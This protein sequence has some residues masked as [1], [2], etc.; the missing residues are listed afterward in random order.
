MASPEVNVRIRA[1]DEA[2]PVLQLIKG[3]LSEIEPAGAR[4]GRGVDKLTDAVKDI[5]RQAAGVDRDVGNL[6]VGLINLAGGGTLV[7]AAVGGLVFAYTQLTAA[8]RAA[9][10][11]NEK[12]VTSLVATAETG[13]HPGCGGDPQHGRG[14]QGSLALHQRELSSSLKIRPAAALFAAGSP[15]CGIAASL[16]YPSSR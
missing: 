12:F 3:R 14:G 7:T 15:R 13:Q 16:V 8:S 11:E 5:G 9:H 10:D 4:A 6:A 1:K 2:T